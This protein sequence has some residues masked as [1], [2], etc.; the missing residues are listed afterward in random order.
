MPTG[1]WLWSRQHNMAGL[2]DR[3]ILLPDRGKSEQ[4]VL[5]PSSY[6]PEMMTPNPQQQA[7]QQLCLRT[8][9]LVH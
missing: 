9:L 4:G 8:K 1:L 3:T 2:C 6:I 5:G 7:P